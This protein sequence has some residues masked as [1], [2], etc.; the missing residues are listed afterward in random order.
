MTPS[1]RVIR[2]A[3]RAPAIV[4]A[5]RL[6]LWLARWLPEPVADR[7]CH[8]AGCLGY[9]TA[10]RSRANV[11]ANLSHV[12]PL[13]GEPELRWLARQVFYHVVRNYYDLLRLPWLDDADLLARIQVEG[14]ER[15]DAALASG[16][17]V[18]AVAPHLGSFSLVPPCAALLGYPV[19]VV[20][21]RLEPPDLH[22]LVVSL[23]AS[24]GVRVVPADAGGVRQA[25]AALRRG[26]LV[27]L[28][29]DRDVTGGGAAVPFFGTPARLPVGPAVLA[30]RAGSVLLPMATWR[31]DPTTSLVSI[32]PPVEII[33]SPDTE[34]DLAATMARLA[35]ALETAISQA[36]DQ[37]VVLQ[38]IWGDAERGRRR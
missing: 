18:I 15:L 5:W 16:R 29:G 37:W 17:G 12:R 7:A 34:A 10:T 32:Q 21:E 33:Q 19:T 1:R 35:W 13:A 23:R 38:A 2:A 11:L 27:V 8:L 26:E 28:V 4:R 6:G 14:R 9:L 22:E 31:L 20:M 36:P 3:M 24:R 30:R 25:L